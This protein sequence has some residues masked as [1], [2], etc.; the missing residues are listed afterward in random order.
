VELRPHR[1]LLARLAAFTALALL[2]LA[3]AARAELKRP[4]S[5]TE[6]PA[7]YART[8]QQVIRIGDGIEKVR[9]ERRRRG[10]LTSA[11]YTAGL[12]RWQVSYF[13]GG[14]ERAQVSIDDRDGAVLEA[15]TGPQVAWKMARGYEGAFGRKLN[16]PYVWLPLCAL[17]LLPFVDPRRPFR[18]LH[19]D[20]LVLLGFGLSHIFFNRGEI[21]T[22]VPLVYPVLG[23]LLA[24][25]LWIGFRPRERRQRLVP[26]LP[27]GLL[28]L[29]LVF[30]VGFR[31][32]LNVIDADV[33]DVGYAGVV[34]ADRIADGDGLYGEFPKDIAHGDTYGPL[35]YLLYVPFEQALPWRDGSLDAAHGAAIAFDLLT[36]L[37]LFVLG[38]RL[39]PGRDGLLLGT[40]LAYAW[41]AY[42]Y[43]LFAMNSNAN[44]TLAAVFVV[45]AL[46]ALASPSGRGVL[47]ALAGAAKLA[48]AALAPLFAAPRGEAPAHRRDRPLRSLVVFGV[49]FAAVT[50]VA[51]AP[52]IPD[53]G[54]R[55]VWDRTLGYQAGRDSP[56]SVWGQEPSLDWLQTVVKVAGVG[57]A[58]FVG[59]LPRHR[60]A[61]QVAALAAAVLIALQLATTHWFY[62]YVVW[63]APL[64]LVALFALHREPDAGRPAEADAEER[65]AREPVLA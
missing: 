34:G 62:L 40:A 33:I 39:R 53:G 20:L 63:F 10:R 29:A 45:W 27:A 19:L 28:A 56:F 65:A 41:A 47:V 12:R 42:P 11:A 2:L 26:Y 22:S 17:F 9:G 48:P 60:S 21:S 58:L 15:W 6:P 44:D 3:P 32:G 46:V 52:F 5:T 18:L 43:S 23:Y 55:E 4:P 57:L 59:F 7:G 51:F 24:R 36:L 16:A 64:V 35:T 8:A 30:L 25:M 1:L 54:V 49:A 37:G 14:K 61:A 13:Q 38:R 50:A 31:I